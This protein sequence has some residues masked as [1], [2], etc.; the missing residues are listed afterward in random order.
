MALSAAA[1]KSKEEDME[2]TRKVIAE[3]TGGSDASP[4]AEEKV[5]E[6]APKKEAKKSKKSKKAEK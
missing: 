1:A 5:E 3:F 2:L 6:E 4:P